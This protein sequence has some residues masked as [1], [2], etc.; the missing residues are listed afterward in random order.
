MNFACSFAMQLVSGSWYVSGGIQ[1]SST[2]TCLV[3][4]VVLN[5]ASENCFFLLL[6]VPYLNHSQQSREW[7]WMTVKFRLKVLCCGSCVTVVCINGACSVL[8]CVCKKLLLSSQKPVY[9]FINSVRCSALSQ[10]SPA[11]IW[12]T[13]HTATRF[14]FRRRHTYSNCTNADVNW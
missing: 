8:W 10:V 9:F 1:V 2:F 4:T 12:V 13:H 5:I 6:Q 14:N 7:G 11:L 3:P